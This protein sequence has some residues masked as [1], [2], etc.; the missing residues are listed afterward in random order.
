MQLSQ[1]HHRDTKPSALLL[2]LKP[3]E[4]Q[5]TYQAHETRWQV[6][7]CVMMKMYEKMVKADIVAVLS[8]FRNVGMIRNSKVYMRK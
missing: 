4:I 7:S 2:G 8:Y 3:T 5:Y 1:F 6:M